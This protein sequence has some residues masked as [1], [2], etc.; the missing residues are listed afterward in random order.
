MFWFK[1]FS[2]NQDRCAMKVGTDGVLLGACVNV[3]GHEQRI[4]DIGTGTGLIALMVAQRLAEKGNTTFHIDAVEIDPE[5]A[6]QA[7][8]NFEASPWADHLQVHACSLKEY[9]APALYDL[10]VCNPPFYNATLKP[11]DEARAMARHKDAL[12]LQQ[13]MQ[14]A[15][16]HLV[17]DGRLAMIYPMD[18]DSEVQTAAVL[19]QLRPVRIVNILTKVG[20]PCKRRI[21]CLVHTNAQA[22]PLTAQS[23]SLRDANNEYSQEYRQITDSFYISLK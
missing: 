2:V 13:I 15:Q 3:N 12:P 11:D 23:L 16:Q 1:Q 5:A 22:E 14:F 6:A 8:E 10:I 17:N 19:A 21:C 9:G 7:K 20:K 18:Y 4:L